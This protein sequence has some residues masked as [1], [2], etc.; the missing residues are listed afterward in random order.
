MLQLQH[1][2]KSFPGIKAL[3]DVSMQF[4][5][6]E[7][8][9]LCGE[10]GAGNIQP[11]AGSIFLDGRKIEITTIQLAQQVGISI[12]YQERSSADAMTVAGN[13]FPV[14]QPVNRFGLINYKQLYRQTQ[15]LLDELGLTHLSPVMKVAALSSSQKQMVE[16]AKALAQNP[17]Y[18]ILDEPTAS[19]ANKE[20]ATEEYVMVTTAINLPLYVNHEQAA[21]K[22]WGEKMGVRISIVG[23]SEQD[24]PARLPHW[25]R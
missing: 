7:V 6:G 9:A 21:V 25:N 24:V 22:K 18:L 5:K 2:S 8:H 1:I 17:A 19:I 3:Q 20:T 10:N 4:N 15:S 14:N 23:P 12:V 13:I 16:I 11:D